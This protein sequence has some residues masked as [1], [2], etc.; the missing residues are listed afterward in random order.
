MLSDKNSSFKINYKYKLICFNLLEKNVFLKMSNFQ[1]IL[2]FIYPLKSM[3]EVFILVYLTTE[4]QWLHELEFITETF[5]S[6]FLTTYDSQTLKVA[7][8]KFFRL[9]KIIDRLIILRN[10]LKDQHKVIPIPIDNC[11]ICKSRLVEKAEENSILTFCIDGY[12]Y[13]KFIITRC[14]QCDVIYH[15]DYFQKN[16]VKY[17]YDHQTNFIVVRNQTAFELKLLEWVDLEI[18]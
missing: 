11:L 10:K 9:I 8:S 17:L 6:I 3:E 2:S 1:S 18:T 4:T 5:N 16:N 12:F 13:K 7:K 14:C 15:H